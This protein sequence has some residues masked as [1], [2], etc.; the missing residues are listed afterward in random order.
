MNTNCK[1]SYWEPLALQRIVRT[2]RTYTDIRK[3]YPIDCVRLRDFGFPNNFMTNLLLIVKT[4]ENN[5]STGC[6]I[7]GIFIEPY[8]L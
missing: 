1:Y 3:N 6:F 8:F 5:C 7:K 2:R 4:I